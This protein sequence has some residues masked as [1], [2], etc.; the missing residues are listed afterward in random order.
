[1]LRVIAQSL[2]PNT[3]ICTI[4][5]GLHFLTQ[6]G[7]QDRQLALDHMRKIEERIETGIHAYMTKTAH[8]MIAEEI[9]ALR[10]EI[11]VAHLETQDKLILTAGSPTVAAVITADLR[12][13]II[14]TLQ[15]R[16][17]DLT[18]VEGQIIEGDLA[19]Q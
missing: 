4:N 16:L 10:T 1:M 18:T 6:M 17:P 5:H 13:E 15:V 9:P 7:A 19:H 2:L 12:H 14:C 8:T 3:K 11:I